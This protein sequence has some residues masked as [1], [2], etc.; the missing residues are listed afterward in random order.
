MQTRW[1]M[2]KLVGGAAFETGHQGGQGTAFL[3]FAYSLVLLA[4]LALFMYYLDRETI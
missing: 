4:D 3:L 2:R 1:W